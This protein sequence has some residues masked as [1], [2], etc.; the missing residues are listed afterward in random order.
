M[1]PNNLTVCLYTS[2]KGHFGRSTYQRTVQSLLAQVPASSWGDLLSHIKV[3]PTPEG[4]AKAK[5]MAAF[6]RE[7]GFHGRTTVGQWRHND[8]SHQL[9]FLQDQMTLLGHVTTPYIYFSEDDWQVRPYEF[10]L[11][12]WL[13]EAV[14]I[15]DKDPSIVQVRIPRFT[16]EMDRINGLKAKH[17][18]DGRAVMDLIES[19]WFRQNDWSNH[20]HVART[21]DLRA[22]LTFIAKTNLPRH[23]E[24]GMGRAMALLSWNE[25]G[26][27]FACFN[28]EMIRCGHIG[29]A[30]PAEEDDLTKPLIA[31]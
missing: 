5:E 25:T 21:R 31:T 13:H 8:D 18:I 19:R 2:S 12:Y 14:S 6:L 11:E 16:N 24:H 23:S 9:G 4:E 27:P 30:S 26:L 10:D 22:A 15:L 1:H 20:P 28:P 3:D 17:N 7:H 29:V